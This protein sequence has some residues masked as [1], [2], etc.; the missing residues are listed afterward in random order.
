M[1]TEKPESHEHAARV[2][3]DRR[4]DEVGQVGEGDDLVE[5]LLDLGLGEAEQHAVDVDVLP[6]CHLAVEADADTEQRRDS[7]PD[8]HGPLVGWLTPA[9][10]RSR[11]DLPAPLRPMIPTVSPRWISRSTSRRAHSWVRLGGPKG[12][13]ER[14]QAAF[15]DLPVALA[16]LVQP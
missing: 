13:S 6:S 7:A 8:D 1:A 14:K 16:T 2:E 4:V 5:A 12:T 3:L 11:V 9:I 10:R 15:L